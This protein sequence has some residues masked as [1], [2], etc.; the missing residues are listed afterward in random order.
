MVSIKKSLML[1][2]WRFQQINSLI[3][4]VG[5]SMTL[6]LQ[7]YPYIGWRFAGLGIPSKMDWL[8]MII[9]FVIIFACAVFVGIIYDVV[10]QLWIEQQVVTIERQPYAKE[11][12]PPKSILNRQYFYIPLLKKVGLE[13]EAEFQAKWTERNMQEDPILRKDVNRVVDWINQYK[14][15]PEDKRWMQDLEKIMNKPYSPKAEGVLKK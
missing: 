2:V 15:K 8:I 5:L 7:V 10:L 4:I 11:K 1:L 13:N 14:L 6:T 9:I 3:I 12:F